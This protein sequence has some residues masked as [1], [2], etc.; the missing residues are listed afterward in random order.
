MEY[1]YGTDV[2]PLSGIGMMFAN[3]CEIKPLDSNRRLT[4][5]KIYGM[6]I[7]YGTERYG[8]VYRY[9]TGTVLYTV[10]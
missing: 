7:S 2:F 9:G 4:F 1:M 8:T 5:E 10:P 6:H 3:T